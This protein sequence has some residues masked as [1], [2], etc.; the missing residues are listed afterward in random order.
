[1]KTSRPRWR[2]SLRSAIQKARSN[3]SPA[4]IALL[5]V[6]N[7]LNTDDAAGMLVIR[8]FQPH[9]F[10]RPDV[11]AIAGGAAPENVAG[12]LRRF[13]PHMV[14]V[15]DAAWLGLDAGRVA[16]LEAGQIGG[17]SALTHGLPL[18]TLVEFLTQET[19]CAFGFLAIQAGDT[20]F[21]RPV[22]VAVRR[23]CRRIVAELRAVV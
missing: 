9:V 12:P 16:W 4:R 19:G 20:G 14:I 8:A 6:G 18:T 11:L 10:G 23:A 3:A 21:D 15:I 2:A 5:G 17:V 22:T 7:E 13:S 1:M